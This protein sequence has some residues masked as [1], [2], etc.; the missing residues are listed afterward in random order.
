MDTL[1]KAVLGLSRKDNPD[2]TPNALGDTNVVAVNNK[3]AA[4]GA[5]KEATDSGSG[6]DLTPD[7]NVQ[8]GVRQ[9]QAI[10]LTWSKG[11]LAA[12]LCL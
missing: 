8:D 11:S 9:I 4:A 2:V 6:H 12:L 10:T 3:E 1:K 5:P 7:D